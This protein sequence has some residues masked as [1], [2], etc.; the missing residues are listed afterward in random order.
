MGR[1]KEL[2]MEQEEMVA[3]EMDFVAQET[4]SYSE[5]EQQVIEAYKSNDYLFSYV[6]H[7]LDYVKEVAYEI[8]SFRHAN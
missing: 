8:W 1:M 6:Q 5:F 2:V 3:D 4:S 7:S